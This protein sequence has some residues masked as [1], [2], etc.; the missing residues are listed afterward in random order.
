MI[1]NDVKVFQ[2]VYPNKN[3]CVIVYKVFTMIVH[4]RLTKNKKSLLTT[5]TIKLY[6]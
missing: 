2:E 3:V 4:L 6:K 5:I 1:P